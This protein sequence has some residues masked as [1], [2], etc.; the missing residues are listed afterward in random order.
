M[1]ALTCEHCG[2]EFETS[3]A[4]QRFCSGSCWN[5][6]QRANGKGRIRGTCHWCGARVVK[7]AR[8][9]CSERIFCG[10]DCYAEYR[11]H[12]DML[13]GEDHPMYK[14]G[15]DW[16]RHAW[17]R[18][19]E[20]EA[21]RAAVRARDGNRCRTCGATERLTVH[22]IVSTREAPELR[23]DPENGVVLCR[24]CHGRVH[25]APDADEER[26]A[27]AEVAAE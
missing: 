16:E 7:Y 4:G 12:S 13:T 1:L 26:A 17:D 14:G 22:H 21:W 11:R 15:F 3:R 19:D 20:A 23:A 24:T 2:R 5:L 25:F 10:W 6:Y 9:V 8:N 27:L 18:S